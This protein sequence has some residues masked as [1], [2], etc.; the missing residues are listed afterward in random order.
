MHFE[1]ATAAR[2]VFGPA[3]RRELAPFARSQGQRA[4]VLTGNN[5]A[6]SESLFVALREQ[7][8]ETMPFVV[9]SEPDT[10]LVRAGANQA[11]AER[12]AM[13]IAIGGGSVLDAGKAVAML[14]TNPGDV[15]D[16]LEVVGHGKTLTVPGLPF[17]A[18]P[19]T[20]GTGTEVTRNAVIASPEHQVKASL[21][22]SL[23]LARLAVVDPELTLQLPR[24]LTASTGLDALTQLIEP[25][26]SCRA[27]PL[28][29]GLCR[30]GL[31][32]AARSLEH[33][34]NV[35]DDLVAREDMALASLFSGL[36]LANAGLGAVHGFA[37]P[38]GGRFC[39]AHGAVCAA[40]LPQVMETN[41]RALQRRQPN[42]TALGR[43]T[44][45]ARILTNR[46][47]ASAADGVAWVRDLCRRLEIPALGG[48]GI[49]P[50]DVP[51]LCTA[52]AQASSMKGN[53]LPLLQE[54]LETVL[55][56]SL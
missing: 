4:L 35:P 39:A 23:L 18:V 11:R 1:F 37:A 44:E 7:G 36:A 6:R 29:D 48:Y 10:S 41:I 47:Q 24:A 13:V 26:V 30:E 38:I 33:A 49:A 20:A 56:R 9:K 45:I 27:N 32:R 43:Y 46:A 5:P 17:L 42:S 34:C 12:C 53:P 22:S 54:E 52:A 14:A 2:I 55:S 3:S 15:L 40:L 19:T 51:A 25:Y 31:V 28:V 50:K 16:Y 8:I 21:R